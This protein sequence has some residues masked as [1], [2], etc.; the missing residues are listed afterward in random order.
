MLLRHGPAS[1]RNPFSRLYWSRSMHIPGSWIVGL[2]WDVNDLVLPL[3]APKVLDGHCLIREV[4][5]YQTSQFQSWS[6]VKV[7]I[8]W[9]RSNNFHPNAYFCWC[10]HRMTSL[11]FYPFVSLELSSCIIFLTSATICLGLC[12]RSRIVCGAQRIRTNIDCQ[13]E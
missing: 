11:V 12:G 6:R 3:C 8:R 7:N 4:G 2:V 10:C 13:M 1:V 9:L 5:P